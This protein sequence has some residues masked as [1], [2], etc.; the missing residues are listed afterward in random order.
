MAE[1]DQLK[2]I[3]ALIRFSYTIFIAFLVH[4]RYG[5]DYQPYMRSEFYKKPP[6][7]FLEIKVWDKKTDSLVRKKK[8]AQSFQ[9]W[10]FEMQEGETLE[11]KNHPGIEGMREFEISATSNFGYV[12]LAY[13]LNAKTGGNRTLSE[14]QVFKSKMEMEKATCN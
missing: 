4:C 12:D 5:S 13:S 14:G 10:D 9:I 8:P 6:H 1:W 3:K 7:C 2:P 11:F